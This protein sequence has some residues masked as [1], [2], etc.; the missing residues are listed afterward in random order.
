[1]SAKMDS[2]A[3]VAIVVIKPKKIVKVVPPK[4]KKQ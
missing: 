4:P 2:Q 1:M 3:G